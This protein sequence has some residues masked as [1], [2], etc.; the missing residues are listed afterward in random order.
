MISTPV[1]SF[2]S[3]AGVLHVTATMGATEAAVEKRSFNLPRG[4][5]TTTLNQFSG[6]SGRHIIYLME[7]VKGEQTN[8]VSGD[9]SPREALE[10]MLEGT[11]LAA[12]QDRAT[13][14]FVISRRR[15]EQDKPN[16]TT[17]YPKKTTRTLLAAALSGWLLANP[18]AE[19]QSTS[20]EHESE[21]VKL[22]AFQISS[23]Q[24]RGYRA[25]NSVSATRANTPISDLPLAIQAFTEY[26]IKDQL[27]NDIF[28]VAKYSPGVTQG[29]DNFSRGS[30]YL[31]RGF[32][33]SNSLK[34][35][36]VVRDFTVDPVVLSRVEVVKGPASV[37]YG[38]IAPGGVVNY[39]T[40]RPGQKFAA[41]FQQTVATFN[42]YRSELDVTGPL[43]DKAGYR[44]LGAYQ[45]NDYEQVLSHTKSWTV[46]PVANFHPFAGTTIT[47]EYLH[48][49][50]REEAPV[51]Q[52]PNYVPFIYSTQQDFQAGGK[53]A[54]P[55]PASFNAQGKQNYRRNIT[56]AFAIEAVTEIPDS[57]SF[58]VGYN[59]SYR[60]LTY[61]IS[62]QGNVRP[63][64]NRGGP[65]DGGIGPYYW[66]RL[67]ALKNF[68]KDKTGQVEAFREFKTSWVTWRPLFGAQL[69]R[70]GLYNRETQSSPAQENPDWDLGRPSTWNRNEPAGP[71]NLA[72]VNGNSFLQQ[73]TQ[74]YYFVNTAALW[75]GR[76]N[77]LAGVRR[78]LSDATNT[79]YINN[80]K[81]SID[82]RQTSPQLG[83]LFKI[84][85]GLSA[86][87]SYS[88]SFQPNVALRR[89]ANI[90]TDPLK[91][92]IGK[93]WDIGVKTDLL[94]GKIS[95]TIT[96][97][98]LENTDIVQSVNIP[99]ST[100]TVLT[101]FQS[102]IQRSQGLET[103]FTFSVTRNWQLYA[104]YS[105]CDA[106]ILS[107]DANPSFVGMPLQLSA[108][109][110]GSAW[111]RYNLELGQG[112]HAYL[113]G[114]VYSTSKIFSTNNVRDAYF[115]S[116]TLFDV[117]AGLSWSTSNRI[118]YSAVVAVKNLTDKDNYYPTDWLRGEPRRYVVSLRVDF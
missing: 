2:V 36:Y 8:A 117:S 49:Y 66:R 75:S 23:S 79:N 97:Y 28:D 10:R 43:G 71:D 118:K 16:P 61:F 54:L 81:V 68:P 93:G 114:G 26:F 50:R 111:T 47:A 104:A 24:D 89:V 12:T 108:R 25:S 3:L 58:R 63:A 30:A 20:S 76:L 1:I 69:G 42:N 35:G 107:N 103:D 18:A 60:E 91:P 17:M 21:A 45:E 70:T 84:T 110:T 55:L 85:R 105:Y 116:Y 64:P 67:R 77:L 65:Q 48:A 72:L 59:Y 102:G 112:Y 37:L 11:G 57:W 27:P 41:S 19:A 99:S 106:V 13:G 90:F 94:D 32:V 80:S 82:T 7:H 109:D 14:A 22:P 40:K 31:I 52:M 98:H 44:L 33:S 5:A 39:I 83:A 15:P 92:T 29:N 56:D 4:E 96:A 53:I 78:S 115:P 95:G 101:D 62:G 86:F 34:N 113:A 73:K 46:S 100:G 38:Q 9:F 6:I 88:E 51:W 74:G 87:A